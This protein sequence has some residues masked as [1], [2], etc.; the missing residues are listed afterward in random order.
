MDTKPF[1]RQ[2]LS[3]PS[4]KLSTGTESLHIRNIPIEIVQHKIENPN[5][6][7]LHLMAA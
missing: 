6:Q 7:Q 2:Y 1:L 4:K 3:Y 5:S